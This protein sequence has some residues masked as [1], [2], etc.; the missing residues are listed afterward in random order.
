MEW[1]ERE[2]KEAR[3]WEVYERDVIDL[4]PIL[5]HMSEEGMPV[6][7]KV[8]EA[9]AVKLANEQAR[10][11]K[12]MEGIVPLSARKMEPKHKDGTYGFIRDPSDDCLGGLIRITVRAPVRR[13]SSCGK[14][15]PTKPHFKTYKRPTATRPQ[16]PC[17]DG[18]VLEALEDVERY[19]RLAPLSTHYTQLMRYQEEM[20]RPTPTKWD[21]QSRS[22]KVTMDEKALKDL[23]RQYPEDELYPAVIEYRM[24]DKIAGTYIGRPE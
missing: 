21:N 10:V 13:C 17:A 7:S 23:I 14:V 11:M 22:R 6:D 3:L 24:L 16:N 12:E 2:L 15:N 4:D 5:V 9:S 20:G 19:A 1:I 18:R 8:R